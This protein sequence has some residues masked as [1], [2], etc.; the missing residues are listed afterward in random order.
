MSKLEDFEKL[1]L[2]ER[3][4][5]TLSAYLDGEL[6]SHFLSKDYI[7]GVCTQ[8]NTLHATQAKIGT[9]LLAITAALAFFDHL[10]GRSISVFTVTLTI[11][12]FLASILCL[13]AASAFYAAV[14]SM[15]DVMLID[16]YLRTIGQSAGLFSFDLYTL[17]KTTVNLWSSAIVPKYFGPISGKS[18]HRVLN[19]LH[20]CMVVLMAAYFV[21]P[22]TIISYIA[23][24][25]LTDPRSSFTEWFL[26]VF[27]L[28]L[29]VISW[30]FALSFVIKHRFYTADFSEATGKPTEEFLSRQAKQ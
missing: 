21:F 29:L 19:I 27:A 18:H 8:R 24:S 25:F 13:M 16:A 17:N 1:T 30:F 20:G 11:E 12:P 28:F 9:K 5:K 3:Q 10:S 4:Q 14:T 2:I 22:T 26:V 7:E 6:A 15:I 23:V